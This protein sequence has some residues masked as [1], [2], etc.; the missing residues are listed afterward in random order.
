[1][2]IF[3][4][5]M[6]PRQAERVRKAF[7]KLDFRFASSGD[8]PPLWVRKAMWADRVY[9]FDAF[10]SHAHDAALRAAGIVATNLRNMAWVFATLQH[11]NYEGSSNEAEVHGTRSGT[12]GR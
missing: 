3:I 6:L 11:F 8:P 2:D 9:T 10:R 12:T 1:M 5:G 4:G 7:P